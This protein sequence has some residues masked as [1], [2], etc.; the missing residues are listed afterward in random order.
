MSE[1]HSQ[2]MDKIGVIIF[3]VSGWID[4]TGHVTLWNY[5]WQ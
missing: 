5:L 4:A 3:N 2:L 1:A